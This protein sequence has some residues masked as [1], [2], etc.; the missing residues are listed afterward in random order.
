[1]RSLE[2]AGHTGFTGTVRQQ[3]LPFPISYLSQTCTFPKQ[4]KILKRL[5]LMIGYVCD[6][7]IRL[8]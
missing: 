4:V 2:T 6:G 8:S 3:L 1:M 5:I 7:F